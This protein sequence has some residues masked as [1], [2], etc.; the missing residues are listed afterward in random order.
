MQM[1]QENIEGRFFGELKGKVRYY[2]CSAFLIYLWYL[3][4]RS[5]LWC[6]ERTKFVFFTG[7]LYRMQVNLHGSPCIPGVSLYCFG[8]REKT[9]FSTKSP[10]KYAILTPKSK[11][12]FSGER[13]LPPPLWGGGH[14]SS[15]PT[16]LGAFGARPWPPNFNSSIR[17][18]SHGSTTTSRL[19]VVL[20]Y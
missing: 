11:K 13:A 19:I 16:P 2:Y 7:A 3:A 10:R 1:L 12:K 15:Y 18:C 20:D 4:S 14:P 6:L 17:L 8:H 9:K 5:V